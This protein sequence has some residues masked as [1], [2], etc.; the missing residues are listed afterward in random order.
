[1]PVKQSPTL[2]R[3]GLLRR[4]IGIAL[5]VKLILLIGLWFLLFRWHGKPVP[6]DMNQLFAVPAATDFSSQS[7]KESRDVR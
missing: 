5:L 3:P 6:A 7:I 2:P 1:M 4:Q